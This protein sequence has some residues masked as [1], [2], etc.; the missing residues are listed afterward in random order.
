MEGVLFYGEKTWE[1]K[2][3]KM[4]MKSFTRPILFIV[5]HFPCGGNIFAPCAFLKFAHY[6]CSGNTLRHYGVSR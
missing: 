2:Q 3:L 5:H 4:I 1:E 6:S